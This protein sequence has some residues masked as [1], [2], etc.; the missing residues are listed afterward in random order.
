[1]ALED[2]VHFA[3]NG[4][5]GSLNAI[6]GKYGDNVVREELV[7]V[8]NMLIVVHCLEID[9]FSVNDGGWWCHPI[10]RIRFLREKGCRQAGNGLNYGGTTGRFNV[11][12]HNDLGGGNVV[13]RPMIRAKLDT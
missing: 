3:D 6:E 4:G 5:A 13:L 11:V 1:M 12:K 7:G 9:T 10:F 2:G 8:D